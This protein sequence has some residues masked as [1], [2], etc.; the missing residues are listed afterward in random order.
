MYLNKMKNLPIMSLQV[1][2]VTEASA[3]GV[4]CVLAVTVVYGFNMETQRLILVE[5]FIALRAR[6]LL[7]VEAAGQMQAKSVGLSE[8]LVTVRTRELLLAAVDER[9]LLEEVES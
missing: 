7:H 9:V 3:A 8:L 2:N 5:G 4:A 1:S 6:V